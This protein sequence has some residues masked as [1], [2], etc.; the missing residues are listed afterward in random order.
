MD[1]V[2]K[3]GFAGSFYP[4]DS[5]SLEALVRGFLDNHC[6][7]LENATGMVVPHA[8]YTY[9]GKTAG[10]GFASAPDN[11]STVVIIAPSHR[12]PF[13]GETVFE[14]DFMETPLGMC[15]VNRKVTSGLATRMGTVVF[16]EHSL[17]VMVPFIQIRWP[18]AE[19]VPVILGIEPDC[20]KTA[21]LIQQYAPDAFIVASSDL[22]HFYPLATAEKL[23]RL[24]IDA[25]LTLSPE[26]ITESLEACGK[27]AIRTLLHVSTLRKAKNAVELHY[28]TSA[29][30]GAGTDE[31]VGYFSGMVIK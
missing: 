18:D 11:V 5:A 29:D 8:G 21:R 28:S 24:V 16:N 7:P 12:Y 1:D 26:R 30:A 27:S 4:A 20:R 15:P 10:Y 22:S 31:V 17:E 9:S 13:R 25:F 14:T 19:I 2:L 3:P 23:D 6:E